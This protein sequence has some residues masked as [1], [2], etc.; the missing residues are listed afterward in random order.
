MNEITFSCKCGQ[1]IVADET[2]FGQVLGCP[3][4]GEDVAIPTIA[5]TPTCP[6]PSVKDATPQYF[7]FDLSKGKR[8]GPATISQLAEAWSQSRINKGSILERA[9]GQRI[10]LTKIPQY[11]QLK[12]EKNNIIGCGI[13]LLIIIAA[14]MAASA[15]GPSRPTSKLDME[16]ERKAKEWL[17]DPGNRK[18]FN[19]WNRQQRN[20]KQR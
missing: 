8:V 4:C 14:F 11:Q 20:D 13:I 5:S 18:F 10:P 3:T 12:Q 9:D 19:E 17:S 15:L 16:K 1:R 2:M 6:T 7:Y